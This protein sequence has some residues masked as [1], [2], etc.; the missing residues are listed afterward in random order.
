M[1]G[2]SSFGAKTPTHDLSRRLPR[3]RR[4]SRDLAGIPGHR[5]AKSCQ[6]GGCEAPSGKYL[7]GR[8]D[9][10][11]VD[12]YGH[13]WSA[14]EPPALDIERAQIHFALAASRKGA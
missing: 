12:P 6:S 13:G 14:R 5:F 1:A 3:T 11:A 7:N 4:S 10:V 9:S 2:N 8:K